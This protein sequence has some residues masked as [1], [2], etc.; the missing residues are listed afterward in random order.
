MFRRVIYTIFGEN[1]LLLAQNLMPFLHYFEIL[2]E[3]GVYN[4][5]K[6]V[7]EVW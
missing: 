4:T 6:H 3:D 2:P 5:P 7:A 1:L